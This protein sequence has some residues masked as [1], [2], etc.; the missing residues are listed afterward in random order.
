MS[1]TPVS[2][3]LPRDRERSARH[4]EIVGGCTMAE[5]KGYGRSWKKWLMIYVAVG[6]IAF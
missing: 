5:N 6:A 2:F 4:I 3:V 1:R